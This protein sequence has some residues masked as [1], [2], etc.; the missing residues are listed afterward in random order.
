MWRLVIY[1]WLLLLLCTQVKGFAPHHSPAVKVVAPRGQCSRLPWKVKDVTTTT[2]ITSTSLVLSTVPW[3][4]PSQQGGGRKQQLQSFVRGIKDRL[5][6][7]DEVTLWR[8]AALTFIASAVTFRHAIDVQLLRLWTHLTTS[9]SLAARIFRSDSYEWMLA[10]MAF[11]VY[12]HFFG[13]ADRVV[14]QASENG[15]V[16]PWRQYR[17]QDRFEADK[18]RRMINRRRHTSSR[19]E[20]NSNSND[21]NVSDD[22]CASMP[23][24]QQ[25][26]WHW[27]AWV[28]EFWVYVLPLLTW[29]I[30]SPRRH[31]RLAAFGAPTT[32][33][34]MRDVTGG[35]LLY[36][37]LFFCG[38]VVM[39]KVPAIYKWIHKKHHHTEEVRACEI[40]RLSLLEEVLEVGFSIVALNALGAHPVAR[41]LYNLIIVFLLTE[42][43]SGFDFPWTPQNVVP[44]GL[45]TGS[46]RHH[47]HHRFGQHYYQKFFFT[48]DRLFGF[49]Q[50]N[51]G[52]LKGDSVQKDP[53]I[54]PSWKASYAANK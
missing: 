17:L 31:R 10:V 42:L 12:I 35:L 18:H 53:Y 36:D 4:F 27:Q 8:G 54:P 13:H 14:R 32:V 2:H 9:T 46:R 52:S 51:D 23:T 3:Q 24:V 30:L 33:Q 28:F 21:D 38:H 34:I 41:S 50:R 40:V 25:S 20:T 48:W 6:R 37:A 22:S 26:P 47:Y 7:L 49:F 43:H 1:S 45:A 11:G 5:Y 44:F 19:L 39:H 16:H 29:D 15:R